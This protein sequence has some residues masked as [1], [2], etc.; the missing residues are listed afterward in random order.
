MI[1]KSKSLV[2]LMMFGT[3]QAMASVTFAQDDGASEA[4]AWSEEVGLASSDGS[5]TDYWTQRCCST[6]GVCNTFTPGW[7]GAPCVCSF[8]WGVYSGNAC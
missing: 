7:A 5:T 2:M 3:V 6:G 4:D 1:H 8:P